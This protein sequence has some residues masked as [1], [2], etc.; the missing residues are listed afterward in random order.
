MYIQTEDVAVDSVFG[1]VIS[2]CRFFFYFRFFD[3]EKVVK[4]ISIQQHWIIAALKLSRQPKDLRVT[5]VA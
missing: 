2:S 3:I 5:V 4:R 1:K